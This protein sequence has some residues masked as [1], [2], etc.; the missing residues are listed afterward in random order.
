MTKPS[1]IPMLVA[2]AMVA[3]FALVTFAT[4]PAWAIVPAPASSSGCRARHQW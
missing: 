4:D 1:E 3:A 2:G